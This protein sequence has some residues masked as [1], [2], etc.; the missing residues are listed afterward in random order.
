MLLRV[1]FVLIGAVLIYANL[2]EGGEFGEYPVSQNNN[3][4]DIPTGDMIIVFGDYNGDRDAFDDEC[5][6]PDS[7]EELYVEANRQNFF[8]GCLHWMEECEYVYKYKH[9]VVIIGC[10]LC[11]PVMQ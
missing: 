6:C 3:D 2:I 4:C 10:S 8:T 7:F 9:T 5:M 1:L 11:I